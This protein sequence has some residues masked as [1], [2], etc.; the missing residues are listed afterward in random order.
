MEPNMALIDD[1]GP[2]LLD[3]LATH[4]CTYCDLVFGPSDVDDGE[5]NY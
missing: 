4:L 2:L 5:M 1:E 3:G